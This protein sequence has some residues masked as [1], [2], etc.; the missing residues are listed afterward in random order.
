MMRFLTVLKIKFID[1]LQLRLLLAILLISPVLLGLIAGTANL[2]NMHTDIQAAL[3]DQDNTPQSAQLVDDLREL[4]WT[5][6]LVPPAEAERLLLRNRVDGILTVQQ[7]Y[8]ENLSNLE[9]VKLTY[10]Q[11]EG[12]LLTTVVEEGLAAAV[13]PAYSRLTNLQLARDSYDELGLLPPNNLGEQF[14]QQLKLHLDGNAAI[15]I[16]YISDVEIRPTLT[17]VV[18]DYSM[19]VFFLS[20][21]AVLGV[22]TISQAS[23]RRRLAST[24]SGLVLDYTASIAALMTLGLVQILAYTLTMQLLMQSPLRLTEVL[25]LLDYLLLMLGLGQLL[26]L[27]EQSLRLYLSLLVLLLLSVF[28]GC[29]FQLSEKMLSSIGQYTPMGWVLHTIKGYDTLPFYLPVVLA[30]LLLSAGYFIQKKRAI[31]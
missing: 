29:F 27:I 21:Y 24:G 3:I 30:V 28:G 4:G 11:A 6:L 12:S 8:A 14:D 10:R 7:G 20:I 26:S 19:E 22:M 2:K 31:Q 18:S 5:V 15:R 1:L 13:L 17:F 25:L 16:N 9:D 23:L